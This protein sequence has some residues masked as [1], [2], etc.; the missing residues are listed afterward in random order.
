MLNFN[1][2]L[3]VISLLAKLS[4]SFFFMSLISFIGFFVI[5]QQGISITLANYFIKVVSIISSVSIILLITDLFLIFFNKNKLLNIISQFI[6][7]F[8]KLFMSAG[9]LV[10]VNT[11]YILS[12][13]TME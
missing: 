8:I 12:L 13:G 11:V 10:F 4:S 3:W 6:K 1:K 9:I 5:S 7:H 2:N